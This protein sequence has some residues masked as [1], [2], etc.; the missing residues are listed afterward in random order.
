MAGAEER[1]NLPGTTT[2][3]ANKPTGYM[4]ADPVDPENKRVM[5][6]HVAQKS[7]QC[8]LQL[9]THVSRSG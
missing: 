5:N 4:L 7:S 9:Q 1:E 8:L 6:N 3:P 2:I